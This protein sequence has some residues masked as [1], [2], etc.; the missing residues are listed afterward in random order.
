MCSDDFLTCRFWDGV[1]V[2][3]GNDRQKT[4][5]EAQIQ[6]KLRRKELPSSCRLVQVRCTVR[7]KYHIALE[8]L[9]R[10]NRLSPGEMSC[11]I[12]TASMVM[13]T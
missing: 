2:T 5:Y 1:V 9:A 7:S 6:S 11:G 4:M 12:D 10:H 8:L 3:A 13:A